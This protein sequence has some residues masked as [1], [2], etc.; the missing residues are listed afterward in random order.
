MA[1]YPFSSI[2]NFKKFSEYRVDKT[3]PILVV[4]FK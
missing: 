4:I 3:V 1:F 2:A